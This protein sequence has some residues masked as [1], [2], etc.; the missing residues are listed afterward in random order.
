MS[1]PIPPEQDGFPEAVGKAFVHIVGLF[2]ILIPLAIGG[3]GLVVFGTWR[4]FQFLV[5]LFGG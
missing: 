5:W 2:G 3:L 4:V 1:K